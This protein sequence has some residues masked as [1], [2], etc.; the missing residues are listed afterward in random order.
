ML[1][2]K[3]NFNASPLFSFGALVIVLNVSHAQSVGSVHNLP[4]VYCNTYPYYVQVDANH[5]FDPRVVDLFRCHGKNDAMH[6]PNI[7]CVAKTTSKVTISVMRLRDGNWQNHILVNHTSCH[8]VCALDATSCSDYQTYDKSACQCRCHQKSPPSDCVSPF[9]WD[10]LSC[11]CV[12]P[13]T[14]HNYKCESKK[15]FN[16]D[17][18]GCM[19]KP[20]RRRKCERLGMY[21]DG[22][23]CLCVNNSTGP[24]SGATKS[25]QDCLHQKAKI[26]TALVLVFEAIAILVAFYL[27][28]RYYELLRKFCGCHQRASINFNDGNPETRK[29]DAETPTI[30]V[31]PELSN[32]ADETDAGESSLHQRRI[33]TA[34]EDK[35]LSSRPFLNSDS[36]KRRNKYRYEMDNIVL[37]HEHEKSFRASKG[38]SG[39][40]CYT[41]VEVDSDETFY[42]SD[43]AASVTRV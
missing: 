12:C 40:V 35:G 34:D 38:K 43:S 14:E 31:K 19:C 29:D 32:T 22:N 13:H 6:R 7:K 26:I 8:E 17:Y 16:R 15:V 3:K 9:T 18:C 28:N 30:S 24:V 37:Y 1:K 10:S 4:N 20:N 23:S 33:P 42:A 21:L 25:D 2:V 5:Q 27:Y 39:S 36:M 41:D 11:D